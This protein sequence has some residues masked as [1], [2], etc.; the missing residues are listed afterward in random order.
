M[1][2]LHLLLRHPAG[3]RCHRRL[4]GRA[5]GRPRLPARRRPCRPPQRAGGHGQGGQDRD[6]RPYRRLPHRQAD[7]RGRRRGRGHAAVR[8]DPRER[9]GRA[10]GH[11]GPARPRPPAP[12]LRRRR[13]FDLRGHRRPLRRPRHRRR[14]RAPCALHR[15]AGRAAPVDTRVPERRQPHRQRGPPRRRLARQQDPRR[16]ARRPGHRRPRLPDHRPLP[17][18]QR[19]AR[20]R[21]RGS[22][23]KDR[24]AGLRGLGLARRHRGRLSRNPPRLL[25][26]G[27]LP[28]LRQLR[29]R[30]PRLPRPPPLHQRLSLALRGRA[31]VSLPLRPQGPGT[32]APGR[33]AQRARREAAPARV[34]HTRTPRTAGDQR[35]RGR[36]GR[37]PGRL[38]GGHEGLRPPPRPQV[39]TGP[40][41]AG[42]DL[43]E[44]S[45]RHVPGTDRHRP[46]RRT[47][48]GR[49]PR[50]P[51]RRPR[52][53][54]GGRHHARQPLRAHGHRGTGRRA[55]GGPRRHRRA[56]TAVRRGP[57][58]GD[59]RRTARTRPARR[60]PG[61]SPGRRG[62]P[63][64]DRPAR[65]AHGPRTRRRHR[66]AGHQPPGGAGARPGRRGPGRP[67]LLPLV[68]KR[69]GGNG[70]GHPQNKELPHESLPP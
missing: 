8:R 48:A 66:R 6:R 40:G 9:P 39:G 11:R 18:P 44:P 69:Q 64:G 34:R 59:A 25:A 31:E 35:R 21:P 7:R 22:G 14:P 16:G 30:D 10:P 38:P 49:H 60:R 19:P 47:A 65:P 43:R 41:P 61:G 26:R 63:R 2:R 33:A 36:T 37:R 12:G 62:R 29:H 45:A 52:H 58:P 32:A 50:L 15:Q 4:C 70:S 55:D 68:Y 28:H 56:R 46:L 23:G 67:R 13:L 5:Q 54:D 17:A 57:R 51:T 3:G 1:R 20:P 42:P 53:R 27:H 24:Q